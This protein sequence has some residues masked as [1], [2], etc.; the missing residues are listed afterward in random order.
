ML[1][2][3]SYLLVHVSLKYIMDVI[4]KRVVQACYQTELTGSITAES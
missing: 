2:A 1:G 4:V 3:I